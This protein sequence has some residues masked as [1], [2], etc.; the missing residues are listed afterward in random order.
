MVPRSLTHF[1]HQF[2]A[3]TYCAC[4]AELF[5]IP[6]L[7]RRSPRSALRIGIDP[8]LG[9]SDD[10]TFGIF[11]CFEPVRYAADRMRKALS[12]AFPGDFRARAPIFGA[13]VHR[14]IGDDEPVIIIKISHV[15]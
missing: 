4:F 14:C 3:M 9:E 13:L 15:R 5:P 1:S 12:A 10:K 2:I 8:R 7:M 11:A 6:S